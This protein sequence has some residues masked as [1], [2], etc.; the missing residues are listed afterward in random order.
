M[1]THVNKQKTM[2]HIQKKV[3]NNEERPRNDTDNRM[4]KQFQR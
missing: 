2:V 1:T 3:S 4:S